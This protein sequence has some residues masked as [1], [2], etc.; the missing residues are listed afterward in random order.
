MCIQLNDDDDDVLW[1]SEMT[2]LFHA[3]QGFFSFEDFKYT[4]TELSYLRRKMN[5]FTRK[6][7]RI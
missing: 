7:K 1:V 5:K 4:F 6:K 2:M 3:P